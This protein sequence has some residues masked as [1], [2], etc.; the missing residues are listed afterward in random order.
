MI[1]KKIIF[2]LLIAGISFSQEIKD[3]KS[4]AE[5]DSLFSGLKG[6]TV[7]VNFWATW[8]APCKK[9][10]PD[11]IKLYKNYKEKGFE[12][13]LI[14]VDDKDDRNGALVNYL[15]A[16][17]IDFTVYFDALKKQEDIMTYIDDSWEG[18]IPKSYIYNTEG[19]QVKA[20]TGVQS[21]ESL[22]NEIKKVLKA[23]G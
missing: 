2:I 17:N 8:C 9:E 22:E 3:I 11:L 12:L 7:L 16:L 19:K 1:S 21:Y 20:L 14:S 23:E 18:E 5:F 4:T 6:K 13:V 10:M 15:K